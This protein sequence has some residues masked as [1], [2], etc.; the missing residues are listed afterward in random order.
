MGIIKVNL[1]QRSYEIHIG[2]DLL[3][4]VGVHLREMGYARKAI[5]ITNPVVGSL[6]T[7]KL[8]NSLNENGF[9]SIVLEVPDGEKYKTLK[10]AGELY[11]KLNSYQAD[12]QT[13]IL[14]LGGGVIGDLAGFVAA[15][16]MRGVPLVQ[17][18]TTLLAQVD[19]SIG[20][21]VAVNHGEIKNN[22]GTFYQPDRVIAD[23][24]TLSSL[25]EEEFRNGLSE[26]IKYGI[27]LDRALFELVK[28]NMPAL[29]EVLTEVIIRCAAIKARVVE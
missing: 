6:Y 25:P 13:P 22:I 7:G 2:P 14:A 28:D 21:K 8:L 10:Q 5:V 19:S 27:I 16:Y 15:T 23:T 18:P 3:S 24:N 29:G 12:R 26:V 17:L 9:E 20:G 1:S 4:R 11:E